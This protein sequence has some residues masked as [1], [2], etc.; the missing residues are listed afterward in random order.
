MRLIAG[1]FS[2]WLA[3]VPALADGI[4]VPP[5]SVGTS[6]P[7]QVS[8]TATND[9]AAAGKVG[10]YKS[11]SNAETGQ[12]QIG[13]TVTITIAA[14]GVVTWGTTTPFACSTGTAGG[15]VVNFT[16][17]GALPTGIVAGTNYYAICSSISG[18]T[19]QIATSLDN[20]VAGTAITTTGSQS[21]VQTGV[22]TS[23]LASNT[24]GDVA[25]I[26][27]TAGDWEV[28][29]QVGLSFDTVTSVTAMAASNNTT[30]ATQSALPGR[31]MRIA[32]AAQVP[33]GNNQFN[34][35]PARYSLSGNQT[36]YCSGQSVF[37]VSTAAS[38]GACRARRI[39]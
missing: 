30:A 31:R 29:A 37:T 4:F 23:I 9:D 19:F 18:N 6:L 7:G 17:T 15:A 3:L 21:G 13:S 33:N 22:P 10:E 1:L 32:A 12:A 26:Q 25:A 20:A 36:I 11:A 24:A 2:F 16:T 27:L 5:T 35:G 34:V 38:W 8:G 28:T 14:P 39:R